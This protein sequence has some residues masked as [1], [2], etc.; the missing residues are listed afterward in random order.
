MYKIGDFAKKFNVTIKTIRFY[1][2]KGLLKPC[3]VDIYTNY[4]YYDEKNVVEMK[5]I[6][7]LKQLGL[8]LDEIRNYSD[9][10]L[11]SKINKFEEKIKKLDRSIDVLKKLSKKGGIKEMKMFEND[12]RVI[13][14]WNLVGVC[15]KVKD[16]YEGKIDQ[17][18]SFA[19]KELYLMEEGKEYWVI[20]WTKDYIYI[21]DK[22]NKYTLDNDIMF[23][24]LNGM[25]DNTECKYAVYKKENDKRY[26]ID[27]IA[28][29]DN[30]DLEYVEDEKLVG[31]WK[32][33][34]CVMN[35]EQFI[36]GKKYFDGELYVE[37]ISAYDD[38]TVLIAY[39]DG[40][41]KKTNYTKGLIFNLAAKN[42]ACNYSYIDEK[43][44][45]YIIVEWKS[46]DY[47]Y[48]KGIYCY[49]VFE[50]NK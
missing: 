30:I 9:E 43:G 33:V 5:K 7:Y 10:I 21:K 12:E 48:G 20:S 45:T 38:G 34:D 6:V 16:Y 25:L 1:E 37:K 2:K 28:I 17:D 15:K 42:T 18:E 22:A 40:N 39:N 13:G 47:I 24:E 36:P 3:Y 11:V 46:G 23:V 31:N 26:N 8:T 50:K 35:K 4:R 32:A 49:Y 29:K 27:E 19:I 44:K 41:T 14:K